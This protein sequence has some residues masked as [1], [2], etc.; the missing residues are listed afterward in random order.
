L[1]TL[2]VT[3]LMGAF[4]GVGHAWWLDEEL[5]PVFEPAETWLM[6]PSV[7]VNLNNTNLPQTYLAQQ[8]GTDIA[9][10]FGCKVASKIGPSASEHGDLAVARLTP[11]AYPFVVDSVRYFLVAEPAIDGY[12]CVAGM[13]HEVHLFV[14]TA[15]DPGAGAQPVASIQVP[16][17]SKSQGAL[18]EFAHMLDQELKLQ[19]GESLF[20]A[21]Q[22]NGDPA[23]KT[24]M[25]TPAC[26]D[27]HKAD[28]NYWT[29]D[30]TQPGASF[31]WN[32][33]AI[34]GIKKDYIITAGGRAPA[35]AFL[36]LFSSP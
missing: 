29:T 28:A 36:Q 30:G 5:D 20:V 17:S 14:A 22:M 13:A 9:L 32:D 25:C 16:A 7:F 10:Q 34:Y 31:T 15:N 21:I 18:Y 35:A 26:G 23:T 6:E 27:T 2:V 19:D 24:K 4:P 12:Q 11:F 1:C 8:H 33:L 3:L